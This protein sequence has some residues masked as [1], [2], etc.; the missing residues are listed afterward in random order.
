MVRRKKT[1][2]TKKVVSEI[3]PPMVCCSHNTDLARCWMCWLFKSLIALFS[4]F[5]VLWIGFCF[6]VISTQ[7]HQY[8]PDPALNNLIQKGKFCAPEVNNI[9]RSITD[10]ALNNV[11][12]PNSVSLQSKTGAE[13]DREFLIQMI[14]NHENGVELAKLA[15]EKSENTEVQQIAQDILDSQSTEIKS[16]QEITQ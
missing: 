15:L 8:R 4:A 10:S 2:E 3:K 6:G 11:M 5:V 7:R 16:M 13:F 9:S 12:S 14:L 1:T